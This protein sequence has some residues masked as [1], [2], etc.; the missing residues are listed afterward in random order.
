MELFKKP[1]NADIK[2]LES[3]LIMMLKLLLRETKG[4]L[5]AV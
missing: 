2:I 4:R 1:S 3:K 5:S